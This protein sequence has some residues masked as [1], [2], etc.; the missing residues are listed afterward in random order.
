[1]VVPKCASCSLY[2]SFKQS[3]KHRPTTSI[4]NPTIFIPLV[5]LFSSPKS[6]YFLT[7][8]LASNK[9]T[10]PTN[11]M[12]APKILSPITHLLLETQK[13]VDSSKGRIY[14]CYHLNSSQ[15]QSFMTSMHLTHA[16]RCDLLTFLPHSLTSYLLPNLI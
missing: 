13:R 14:S 10:A 16:K 12:S 5:A 1:M 6:K 15:N 4:K 2:S 7:S 3:L 11:A 8:L 9:T